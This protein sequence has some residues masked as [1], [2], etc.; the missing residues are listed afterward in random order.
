M[1]TIRRLARF[2]TWAGCGV[3]LGLGNAYLFGLT[4]SP[5][6]ALLGVALFLIGFAAWVLADIAIELAGVF[7]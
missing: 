1:T 7:K 3:M 5:L 2:A 4:D 6:P